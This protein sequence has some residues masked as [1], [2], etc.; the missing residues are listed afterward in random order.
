MTKDEALSWIEETCGQGWLGLVD[1]V[2]TALPDGVSISQVYQK[3]GVLRFD[4]SPDDEAFT[5][6][7]EMI[8]ERSS[9]ICEKCGAAG[10]LRTVGSW[11]SSLCDEHHK[12][13]IAK[14]KFKNFKS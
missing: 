11:E 2:Y 14:A 10:E 6:Y 8:E 7:L 5:E 13:E 9:R 4:I 12:L 1:E 3:W